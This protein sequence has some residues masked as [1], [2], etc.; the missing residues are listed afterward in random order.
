M[1]DGQSIVFEFSESLIKKLGIGSKRNRSAHPKVLFSND[2]VREQVRQEIREKV[3]RA[4]A[5]LAKR[6]GDVN[7]LEGRPVVIS[8]GGSH[9]VVHLEFECAY[10]GLDA[11]GKIFVSTNDSNILDGATILF[12]ANRT[13]NWGIEPI[14][15]P[16]LE[17][18]YLK[19]IAE[20]EELC[21]KSE[22]K[23]TGK[24]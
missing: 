3:K 18:A 24:G 4:H 19:K 8:E 23:E 15:S 10:S 22:A 5:S 13:H 14:G 12:M 21:A 9:S 2:Y 17:N 16:N 1:L 20:I 7:N 6:L 11:N